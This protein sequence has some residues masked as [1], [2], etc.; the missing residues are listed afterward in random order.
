MCLNC[1]NLVFGDP[2]Y[3]TQSGSVA[4]QENTMWVDSESVTK[5]VVDNTQAPG[6]CDLCG[7]GL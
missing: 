3:T 7:R 4:D 5:I 6:R 1:A 2:E